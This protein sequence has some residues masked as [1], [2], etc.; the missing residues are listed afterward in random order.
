[1]PQT[2]STP[3]IHPNAG[4]IYARSVQWTPAVEG[5]PV[6]ELVFSHRA[7]SALKDLWGVR[8]ERE[9]GAILESMAQDVD[10]RQLVDLIYACARTSQPKM[11]REDV[12]DIVDELGF[13][14][15]AEL[16]MIAGKV[17]ASASTEDPQPPAGEAT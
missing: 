4:K 11:T 10:S 7:M 13:G 17:T 5:S 14:G 8:T 2:P 9:V 16:V 3:H 12:V 6:V 15:M 1:M